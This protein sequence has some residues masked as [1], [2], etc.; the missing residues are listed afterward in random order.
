MGDFTSVIPSI[1]VFAVVVGGSIVGLS[2]LRRRARRRLA[3]SAGTPG[4]LGAAGRTSGT[5]AG[6]GTP[7]GAPVRVAVADLVRAANIQLVQMDDA[8]RD[9]EEELQFALAE[10]GEQS[11][12]DFAEAIS[13]A[14]QRAS[15]AFALKHRLDDE[16]PDSEQQQRDWSKRI[17]AL[18][19]SALALV[20]SQSRAF[21]QRR[22]AE[23]T[24]PDALTRVRDRVA[25]ARLR[26]PAAAI[27]LAGLRSSFAPEAIADVAS[28][29]ATAAG[30]FDEAERKAAEAEAA[31]TANPLAATSRAVQDAEAEFRRGVALLD[32]VERMRDS[33][34]AATS[35]RA[36]ALERA[37][38]AHAEA[39]ALRGSIEDADAATR[40]VEAAAR[41]DEVARAAAA[42]TPPHPLADLEALGAASAGL[43]EALAV[44]RTAQQRLD[45]ARTALSGALAIATSQIDTAGDFIAGRRGL[46]GADARTRLA[47]A[48]RQLSLARLEAD[49]VAALD[50]A[51]R[52]ATLAT[53]ADSLARYDAS[54]LRG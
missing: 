20:T 32:A 44:A 40:I 37:R 48:Q 7:G 2:A 21:A 19:D 26:L 11:T 24:A 51:R 38:T 1:V 27:T 23:T 41:L 47:E 17:L 45:S 14:K 30:A 4:A 13:T 10:F 52:A 28:N 53:D 36:A 54:G 39:A 49:P 8:I 50:G 31:L 35:G 16:M 9:S 5:I 43:D 18:S 22:R 29:D 15:E 34:A 46:V 12:H 42:R 33:L 3:A 6:N 25:E